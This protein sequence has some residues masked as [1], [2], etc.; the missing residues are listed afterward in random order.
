MGTK[1]VEPIDVISCLPQCLVERSLLFTVNKLIC[2]YTCR[3]RSNIVE[4]RG[5]KGTGLGR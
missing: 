1:E 4:K 2:V 3:K 5:E